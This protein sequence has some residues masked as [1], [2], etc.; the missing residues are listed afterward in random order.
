MPL[1]TSHDTVEPVCFL[2]Q[3]AASSFFVGTDTGVV[4]DPFA[5]GFSR[6][7]CAILEANY[8]PQLLWGST[9]SEWLKQRIAGRTG[10]LSNGDAAELLRETDAPNLK[11]LL[12]GHRS[13]ECNS[14]SLVKAALGEALAECR[15]GIAF[16]L[17]EQSVPSPLWSF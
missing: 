13:R 12:A 16:D 5:W 15:P 14:P 2:I 7:R 10:H 1:A 3:D 8:D 11:I 9:R 17:L 6:A 4:T